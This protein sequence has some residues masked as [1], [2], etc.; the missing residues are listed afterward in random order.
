MALQSVSQS[1][2]IG[3]RILS[4]SSNRL[5]YTHTQLDFMRIIIIFI[6]IAERER[7]N[8]SIKLINSHF[9]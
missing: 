4:E 2:V 6:I 3:K 5:K 8:D 9:I 1:F 7:K